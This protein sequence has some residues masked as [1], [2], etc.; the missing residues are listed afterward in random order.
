MTG[1]QKPKATE[2]SSAKDNKRRGWGPLSAVLVTLGIYFGS[3]TF[4]VAVL[5]F[6]ASIKGYSSELTQ[7]IIE[8]SVTGQF[9]FIAMIGA[10][11]IYL[12]SLFMGKRSITWADIGVKKPDVGK[13]WYAI[14]VYLAYFLVLIVVV[15]LVTKFVPA[16]NTSQEQQIG[17]DGAAGLSLVLVFLSLVVIPSLVEEIMV[18]GFLYGG[19]VKKFSKLLAA[20]MASLLF[21]VAH[22]QFGSDAPLLWVA[23]I[24]TFILSMALIWLRERTGN[25]WAG[26]LVHMIK[27]SIAF[28]SL[29]ILK[30]A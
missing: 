3:Q 12:L 28:A 19:L 1:V 10:V 16:I 6:Y 22:L 17:F 20:I 30:I 15:G 24:D 8:E 11:S 14:P 13:L 9:I 4:A 5:S 23:A 2:A 7:K 21:A 18:R 25:I 26:V 29:F 27:N